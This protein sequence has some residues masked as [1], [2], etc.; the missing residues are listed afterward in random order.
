[1]PSN[2]GQ[3]GVE[4]METLLLALEAADGTFSTEN[5]LCLRIKEVIA[6]CENDIS[7]LLDEWNG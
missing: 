3:I 5:N 1:M 4:A 2:V 7:N 6:T